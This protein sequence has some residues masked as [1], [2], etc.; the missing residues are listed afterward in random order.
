MIS[1]T[2]GPEFGGGIGV[3]FFVANVFSC[4][5]YISGFVEAITNLLGMI[6]YRP[7]LTSHHCLGFGD[8]FGGKFIHCVLVSIVILCLCLLGSG[9]FAKTAVVAL[10]IIISAYA[11]F[12]LTVFVKSPVNITI[13]KD[14]TYA[15]LVPIN[16]SDPTGAKAPNFNLTI[17]ASYTGFRFALSF[18]HPLLLFSASQRL[19]K[20]SLRIILMTTQLASLRISLS[21]SPL[22]SPALLGLW[23]ALMFLVSWL[24]LT[25]RFHE[26]L[27]KQCSLHLPPT[28]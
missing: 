1:R 21:C 9:M 26:A 15:Y 14:N 13:P 12:V 24:D 22:F 23:Q 28:C 18:N 3:L 17:N 19:K 7:A 11:T 6:E 10:L 2:L 4:A 5:L 27:F 25:C 20:T 16:E 8:G